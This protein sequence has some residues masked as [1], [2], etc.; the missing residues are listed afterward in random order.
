MIVQEILFFMDVKPRRYRP[1]PPGA[2][3]AVSIVIEAAAKPK[4]NNNENDEPRRYGSRFRVIDLYYV[5]LLTRFLRAEV[6]D[7]TTR[8]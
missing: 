3:K 7:A 5:F 2:A 8:I 1:P 4:A 6:E